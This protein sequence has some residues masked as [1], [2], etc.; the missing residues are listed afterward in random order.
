MRPEFLRTPL[1]QSINPT[2]LDPTQPLYILGDSHSLGFKHMVVHEPQLFQQSFRVQSHHIPGLSTAHFYDPKTTLHPR[3]VQSMV[4][5]GLLNAQFVPVHLSPNASSATH[6]YL[7]PLIL[8]YV[9]EIDVCE[10]LLQPIGAQSDFRLPWDGAPQTD[11]AG[12]IPYPQIK[13]MIEAILEPLFWGLNVLRTKIGFRCLFL[14]SLPPPTPDDADFSR[15]HRFKCSATL[16]NKAYMAFN[17]ILKTKCDQYSVGFIDLWPYVTHHNQRN[18]RYHQDPIHLNSQSA[19]WSIRLW[20][21]A[22]CHTPNYANFTQYQRLYANAYQNE[23]PRQPNR[24]GQ[25]FALKRIYQATD[26]IPPEAIATLRKSLS[27]DHDVGNRHYRLDWVGNPIEPFSAHIKTADLGPSQLQQVF[28][29]L[30]SE[31]VKRGLESCTGFR[32]T[33]LCCRAFLSLPHSQP[34]TGP[35]AF[36]QDGVPAGLM[37]VLLYL[38]DVDETSGPFEYID[39]LTQQVKRLTGPSGSL[40][41]FDANTLKHRGSPPATKER[42]VLDIIL[43][44]VWAGLGERVVWPGMNHWPVDPCYFSVKGFASWPPIN[45]ETVV[46]SRGSP[47]QR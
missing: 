30:Y 43:S 4:S 13:A 38:T 23:K 35:Q 28:Q 34:G 10:R 26:M 1:P 39:P 31:P 33:V 29:L 5:A 37:R 42:E 21:A 12:M 36:H 8:F 20:L 6:R 15:I 17:H 40:L 7:E 41:V 47:M 16:R 2:A 22:I 11:K 3:L 45:T 18:E 46:L 9:G 32:Y 14:H 25:T 24:M 27:Y 44:P 19:Q